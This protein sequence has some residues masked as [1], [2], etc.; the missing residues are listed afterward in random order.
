MNN[1]GFLHSNSFQ[2]STSS[3]KDVYKGELGLRV[4]EHLAVIMDGN[5]RWANERGL[6]RVAGHKKG[7]STVRMVVEESRRLGVK[8]LTL[9]SFSSEN[10]QRPAREV[11][12]IMSLFRR[13]LRNEV[14][15][16]LKH[17]IRL[18]VI[19]ERQRLPISVQKAIENVESVTKAC[20]AMQLILA[21]S[22]SGRDE[23]VDAFRHVGR[24]VQRGDV[25]PEDISHEHVKAALYL[26]DVPDPDM[27]LRTS[28]EFRISNFLLWQLAYT[29]IVITPTSW[30]S[31][32][33]EHFIECIGHFSNRERRF[34][35]TG[36][37]VKAQ[38]R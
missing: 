16:L 18:R 24:L 25:S 26:P 1:T 2:E 38:S 7:A 20:A 32:T 13:H 19:G 5:G 34:G 29:E 27:L 10:W 28:N 30:P 33:K 12:A 11:G 14:S 6:P 22:Y 9:F 31:L 4:P 17:D 23:L 21:V 37:Q 15:L 36:Q 8:Y 35:L 3:H